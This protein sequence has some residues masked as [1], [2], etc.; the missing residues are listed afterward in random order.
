MYT[1][2][3]LLL[4]FGLVKCQN[5]QNVNDT[6]F[7]NGT[8]ITNVYI[9]SVGGML[10]DLIQS[11]KEYLS[12]NTTVSTSHDNTISLNIQDEPILFYI[13]IALILLLLLISIL[14]CCLIFILLLCWQRRRQQQQKKR[15]DIEQLPP[16]I[17]TKNQQKLILPPPKNNTVLK[18]TAPTPLLHRQPDIP[19]S[20]IT[21]DPDI[22]GFRPIQSPE[23]Q[24]NVKNSEKPKE[25]RSKSEDPKLKKTVDAQKRTDTSS[26]VSSSTVSSPRSIKGKTPR[27][28]RNGAIS[29][30]AVQTDLDTS[31]EEDVQDRIRGNETMPGR[32]IP[33]PRTE[34]LV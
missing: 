23:F 9:S 3:V 1:L 13:I 4:L 30:K 20:P 32:N 16:P 19:H 10:T 7:S 21:S 15:N 8:R 11:L 22:V 25:K 24:K 31:D 29:N 27:Q 12:R 14:T 34:L 28:A 5:S 6:E 2:L 18:S 26:N 33:S 17:L